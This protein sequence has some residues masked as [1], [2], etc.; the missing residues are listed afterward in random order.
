MKHVALVS[1]APDIR[2]QVRITRIIISNLKYKLGTIH[3]NLMNSNHLP[4]LT[5]GFVLVVLFVIL[6]AKSLLL[7]SRSLIA[8]N[9]G[10]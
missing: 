4:L 7:S 10:L 9:T 2:R 6:F 3:I 8:A 5:A 1:H